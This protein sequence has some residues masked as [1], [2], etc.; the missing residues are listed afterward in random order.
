M[1]SEVRECLKDMEEC[2]NLYKISLNEEF[3][4][5]AEELA[6]E[7]NQVLTEMETSLG[8]IDQ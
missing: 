3:L 5:K 1:T 7:I 6:K 2:I 8:I 4:D